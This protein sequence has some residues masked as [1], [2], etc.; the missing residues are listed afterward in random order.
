MAQRKR[1]DIFFILYLT[2]ILGFV[3]VSRERDKIDE[4]M[5]ELNEQIVRTFVPPVPLRPEGD[6]L[7][8]YV[9]A[10]SNGIVIG[11]PRVFETKVFASYNF[12]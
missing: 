7:R 2:A 6:T 12:V 11:D 1:I 10:D 9:D 4:G 3:V 8:C 5:H